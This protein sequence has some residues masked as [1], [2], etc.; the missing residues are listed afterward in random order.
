MRLQRIGRKNDPSYR[1][2]VTDSRT[3]PKSNKYVDHI[4]N[5]NSKMNS[6]TIDGERVKNW[7]SK[8]VQVSDTVHNLLVSNK[9]I[10]GKKINVLSRKSPI[11][12]E[13]KLKAEAEA[14]AAAEEAATIP[15][16][17][18]VAEAAS[19]TPAEEVEV[20]ETK[21][22]TPA[23]VEKTPA[24]EEVVEGTIETK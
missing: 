3:G 9:I 22:E 1:V 4:G 10:E 6:F 14:K 13:A 12:D 11:V 20:E 7:I 21:E 16:E 17:E 19:E 5:Y 2:I 23:E 8:G 18:P 24:T 15:K